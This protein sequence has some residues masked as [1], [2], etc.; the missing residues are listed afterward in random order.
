MQIYDYCIASCN[1]PTFNDFDGNLIGKSGMNNRTVN[2]KPYIDIK[3]YETTDTII[4]AL[5]FAHYL[6]YY[7]EVDG[8]MVFPEKHRQYTPTIYHYT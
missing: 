3:Y 8:V 1:P 7:S 6:K 2:P 4:S 5:N